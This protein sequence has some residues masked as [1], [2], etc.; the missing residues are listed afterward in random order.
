MDTQEARRVLVDYLE[1]YRTLPY[2]ELKKRVN[3][4]ETKEVLTISGAIYQIEIQVLWVDKPDRNLRV[5]GTI[6]D[7]GW[8]TF[9]P[10]MVEFICIPDGQINQKNS[11][12]R[13]RVQILN[14]QKNAM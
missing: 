8:R 12:T 14:P 10:L 6:D 11:T 5:R 4:S 1:K 7:G 3:E 9:Y 2:Q 13:N